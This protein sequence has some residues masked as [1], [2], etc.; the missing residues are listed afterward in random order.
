MELDRWANLLAAQT[1][2]GRTAS[3]GATEATPIKVVLHLDHGNGQRTTT[4]FERIRAAL[5]S[6][7]EP[8]A[9][10]MAYGRGAVV[11]RTRRRS[12]LRLGRG[13]ARQPVLLAALLEE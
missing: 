9:S 1:A 10:E 11:L 12:C 4:E 6:L 2:V 5:R 7:G 13:M 3:K 8:Y